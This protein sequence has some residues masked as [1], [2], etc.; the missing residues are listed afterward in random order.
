MSRSE[1]HIRS[2]KDVEKDLMSLDT[3]DV[4]NIPTNSRVCD[5]ANTEQVCKSYWNSISTSGIWES[6]QTDDVSITIIMHTKKLCNQSQTHYTSLS[7]NCT[8]T[9][10]Q[11]A[12]EN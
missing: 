1:L 3:H 10:V 9:S 2:D 6:T 11:K 5:Q 4:A 12:L 8:P 7:I